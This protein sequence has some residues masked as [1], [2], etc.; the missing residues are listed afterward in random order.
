MKS[1][2]KVLDTILGIGQGEIN[3]EREPDLE[4]TALLR[5]KSVQ[6]ETRKQDLETGNTRNLKQAG[7][8]MLCVV[9]SCIEVQQ[10]V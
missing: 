1:I 8:R 3:G 6:K 4:R 9:I 2:R 10:H 5:D 7:D